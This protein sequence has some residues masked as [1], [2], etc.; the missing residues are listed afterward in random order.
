MRLVEHPQP[1]KVVPPGIAPRDGLRASSMPRNVSARCLSRTKT[2][3]RS[4]Q[5]AESALPHM[6]VL[7]KHGTS[8]REKDEHVNQ[9]GCGELEKRGGKPNLPVP[10]RARKE[11]TWS[12]MFDEDRPTWAVAKRQPIRSFSGL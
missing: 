9:K 1:Q 2:T 5:E 6:T 10:S 8:A 4:T 11:G 3:S 12:S 7:V